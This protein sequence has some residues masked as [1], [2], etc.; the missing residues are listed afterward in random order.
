MAGFVFGGTDILEFADKGQVVVIRDFNCRVGELPNVIEALD[1]FYDPSQIV[2]RRS[3][4]PIVNRFGR[5]VLTALNE[6][7]MVLLNG[8]K[9]KARYTSFQAKGNSLFGPSV[10]S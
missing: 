8:I 6:V 3:E 4:D 7:G 10:M 5:R 1:D 9:E 2:A